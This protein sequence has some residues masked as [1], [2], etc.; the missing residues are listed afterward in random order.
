MFSHLFTHVG[1][2]IQADA[3][4]VIPPKPIKIN[5]T[6]CAGVFPRIEMALIMNEGDCVYVCWREKECV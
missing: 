4:I 1:V 2:C 6:L 3:Q 5:Q